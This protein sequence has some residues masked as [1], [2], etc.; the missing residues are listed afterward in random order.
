VQNF[1]IGNITI[2]NP[3]ILAPM[4]GITDG[5]FRKLCREQGAALVYTEMVSAKGLWYGSAKTRELLRVDDSEKPA[6]YQLF[7]SEP[8][9]MRAAVKELSSE[10]KIL[11]DINMGC[12]VPKVVKNGE[13]SALMKTPALAARVVEAMSREAARSQKAVTVKIRAGFGEGDSGAVAFAKEIEAAGAAAIAIH[14]RTREQYYSG[15]ADW[16]VIADVKSAVNIPVIGSGDVMSG[17]DAVRML[18]QTGCDGVMFARGAL[19]NPWVFREALLY[20]AGAS[21]A[22]VRAAAPSRAQK[23]DMFIRHA[24]LLAGE[25]GEHAAVREMRK[26]VGWYFKGESGVT[27]LKNAANNIDTFAAL[28]TEIRNFTFINCTPSC[29]A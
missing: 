27:A 29:P 5:S 25:K 26:H 28:I 14:G 16:N 24:K 17:A 19:G 20:L 3:F 13:G 21:D 10:E 9:I 23:G 11:I 15:K 4:A 18:D 8:D 2:D 6:A 12:P 7:G 22:D 1:N